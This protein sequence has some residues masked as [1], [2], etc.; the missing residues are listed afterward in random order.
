MLVGVSLLPNLGGVT[1]CGDNCI[2][3][4][5][6][7][8]PISRKTVAYRMLE[9]FQKRVASSRIIA[10]NSMFFKGFWR[11]ISQ[12][13]AQMIIGTS[14]IT[15]GKVKTELSLMIACQHS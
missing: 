7:I 5:V 4:N 15:D 12:A 1:W 10:R 14:I 3:I 9:I 2:K 8:N 6:I 13:I 11:A